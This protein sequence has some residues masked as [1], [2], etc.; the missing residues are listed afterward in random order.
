MTIARRDILDP[1][2]PYW[3]RVRRL[4]VYLWAHGT[5]GAKTKDLALVAFFW[6][7]ISLLQTLFSL[8]WRGAVLVGAVLVFDWLAPGM[9]SCIFYETF[10][11]ST[12]LNGL[13]E[14]RLETGNYFPVVAI[15][16][17]LLALLA[18]I[19][20]VRRTVNRILEIILMMISVI[21]FG[22][23]IKLVAWFAAQGPEIA[24]LKFDRSYIFGPLSTGMTTVLADE[25]KQPLE[26]LWQVYE[27]SQ[28]PDNEPA[29]DDLLRELESKY[30]A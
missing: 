25:Y 8:A 6:L 12:S 3:P 7:A 9:V 17:M 1:N 11:Y 26:R 30:F 14:C 16:M 23:P 2:D 27:K 18:L 22:Y 20:P 10:G 29:L 19:Y 28:S 24:G 13:S 5:L 15:A 21:S 4:H